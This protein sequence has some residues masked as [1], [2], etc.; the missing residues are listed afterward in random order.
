MD[1]EVKVLSVISNKVNIHKPE[2]VKKAIQKEIKDD[3]IVSAI[4][5]IKNLNIPTIKEI[6]DELKADIVFG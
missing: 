4:P 1:K 5:L 6:I 3:V 2:L